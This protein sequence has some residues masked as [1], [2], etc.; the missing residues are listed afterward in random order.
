MQVD[1]VTRVM[2]KPGL[3]T[4]F[5]S[6]ESFVDVERFANCLSVRK[7][8]LSIIVN[9]SQGL[10]FRCGSPSTCGGVFLGR[11]LRLVLEK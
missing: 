1:C 11:A 3:P 9:M 5:S 8:V 7:R 4:Y 2:F 6:A 10:I